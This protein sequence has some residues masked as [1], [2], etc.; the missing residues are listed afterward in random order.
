MAECTAQT[1]LLAAPLIAR[2]D[3]VFA[4]L[5]TTEEALSREINWRA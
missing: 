1:G 3:S 4:R 5:Q 2:R